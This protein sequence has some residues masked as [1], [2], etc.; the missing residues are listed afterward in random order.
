M[1][2]KFRFYKF[3][4][5]I[6]LDTSQPSENSKLNFLLTRAITGCPSKLNFLQRSFEDHHAFV[7]AIHKKHMQLSCWRSVLFRE[8]ELGNAA[9][10]YHSNQHHITSDRIASNHMRLFDFVAKH[11][12]QHYQNELLKTRYFIVLGFE[13]FRSLKFRIPAGHPKIFEHQKYSHLPYTVQLV[14]VLCSTV[15]WKFFR[16]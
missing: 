10:Q 12:K 16:G 5:Q 3:C 1:P 8:R 15:D 9:I 6:F 7:F 13:N 14:I 4:V 11:T 2:R